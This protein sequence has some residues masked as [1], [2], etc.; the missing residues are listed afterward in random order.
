MGK[1]AGETD[2]AL[3]LGISLGIWGCSVS[4]TNTPWLFFVAKAL[5]LRLDTFQDKF[6]ALER[7]V[8]D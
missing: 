1:P 7:R 3:Y 2:A 8:L 5:R 6:G 4:K